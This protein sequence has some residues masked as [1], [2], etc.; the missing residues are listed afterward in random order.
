[1][2]FVKAANALILHAPPPKFMH[3]L[4][5]IFLFNF[6][7]CLDLEEQR[8]ILHLSPVGD[9]FVSPHHQLGSPQNAQQQAGVPVRP[10]IARVARHVL[11]AAPAA[12]A[13]YAVDGIFPQLGRHLA[14]EVLEVPSGAQLETLTKIK[15]KHAVR[16]DLEAAVLK[17]GLIGGVLPDVGAYGQGFG[18]VAAVA[19]RYLV[20]ARS[21]DVSCKVTIIIRMDVY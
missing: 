11:A 3:T 17:V 1:M 18:R 7:L 16:A 2:T 5:I 13:V 20:M 15:A 19:Q 14:R 21:I 12:V 10:A 9:A 6:N 4:T 8:A